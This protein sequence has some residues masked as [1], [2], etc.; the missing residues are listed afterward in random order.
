MTRRLLAL[1][2]ALCAGLGLAWAG[3][4]PQFRGP[5][6]G[7]VADEAG[8]PARWGPGENVRWT[9]DLP[10]RG[11]SCPVVVGS[12]VYLTANSGMSQ[13]RLHML[14]FDADSGRKLWER[15]FWATGP[16]LCNPKTCMAAPTPAADGRGVYALFGTGDLV[17]LD[18][19]GSLR[20]LRALAADYPRVTNQV[21]RGASPVLHED[22]LIMPLEGQGE[23]YLLGIDTA[24][25]RNRWKVA[26]PADLSYT[27]PVL[28]RRGGRAE[29]IVQS[30]REL[31][32]Y[33]P[34]TGAPL[35]S[36]D[37][38]QFADIPSP[39]LAG[40]LVLAAGRGLVALRP[41]ASGPP[42]VVWKSPKYATVTPTPLAHGGRVY[43]VT[44]ADILVCGDAARGKELWRLRLKG[45]FSASPVLVDGRLYLVNE[46]GVTTVVRLGGEPRVVATND[47]KEPMLATPAV[48][49]GCLF[50]R[51]DRHLFCIGRVSGQ[52]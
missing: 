3:D 20:W 21:G 7:G 4:W 31:A 13:T 9:A 46:A 24:A 1:G 26:R 8:L 17:A 45:P 51:S 52:Q 47:L 15:Q 27:T 16:T 49:R 40:D 11:V 18:T 6:L 44:G 50:L 42:A 14:C 33:D 36:T 23:S 12:R 32:A 38:E 35:W 37:G 10:G 41:G 25:G 43:A 28:A 39:V 5:N 2:L 30:P 19:D 29:V 22:V 48:A 34:A